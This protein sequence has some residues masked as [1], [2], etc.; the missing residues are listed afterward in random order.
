MSLRIGTWNLAGRWDARHAAL[1]AAAECDVWLLTEVREDVALP[2]YL[3]HATVEKMAPRRAWARV[4]ARQ[5][6]QPLPDPH[7]ASAAV[8][9][10]GVTYC[11]SI[12]PWRGCGSKHPWAGDKHEQRTGAAIDQLTEGL[13]PAAALVWGGDW[14]HALSGSEYAGGKAGRAHVAAFLKTRGLHVPTADQPHRIPGLLSIDH[15]A[16]PSGWRGEARRVVAEVDGIR[17]S[18][19]DAYV[20]DVEAGFP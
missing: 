14:N 10:G 13:K 9:L 20:V 5:E 12:L 1:L 18:D 19:H 4:L 15:I 2:G 7:P 3:S 16:I 11:S 6:F 17:L 8:T